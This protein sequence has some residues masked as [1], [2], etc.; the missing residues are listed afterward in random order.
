MSHHPRFGHR[1]L[2]FFGLLAALLGAALGLGVGQLAAAQKA[3]ADR[4]APRSTPAFSDDLDSFDPTLWHKADWGNPLPP[5]WNYW[6]PD[7]I[8]FADGQMHIRLDDDSCPSGCGGRPYAAGEYR[9]NAFYGYGRVEARLKTSNVPGI[10]TALFVYTGPSDGKPHDEIDIEILGEDPTKIQVGYFVND[11]GSHETTISL[12]FDASQD[13]HTYAFEWAPNRITWY[14]DGVLVHTES[15]SPLPATPGRIMMSLWAC[16]GVDDWCGR[17]NYPGAPVYAHYDWVAYT[18]MPHYGYLPLVYQRYSPP[19]TPTATPTVTPS[20]LL[21]EDFEDVRDWHAELGNGAVCGYQQD[22]GYRGRGIKVSCTTYEADDWWFVVKPID[23]NWS[24]SAEV[25]FFYKKQADSGDIYVALQDNDAE[26]WDTP[27]ARS[28]TD[29][30]EV[31]VPLAAFTRLDPA[32][33]QGNGILDLDTVRQ[34]RFRHWPGTP[35]D[36]TFW[37]DELRICPPPIT[38][39]WTPTPTAT[40]TSTWTVTPSPTSTRTL[41]PT[42]TATPTPTWTVTPSPTR[43]RTP[44]PTDTATPTPTRTVTPSPTRTRTPTP[45]DT[46]T[47]TPTKTRAP[48]PTDTATPT[49]TWTSTATR[50]PTDTPT[51]T[52]VSAFFDDLDGYDT[53]RWN[54]ADGWANGSPFA[55][56]WRADHI[57]HADSLMTLTLDD[58]PCPGGCS[59]M[60]YAC[61]EYRTDG[62]YGYGCYEARFKAAPDSGVVTSFFTYAKSPWDV[63]SGYT[64]QRN[65][66]DME[67]IGKDTTKLHLNFW[68]NSDISNSGHEYTHT[69]GFD[70]AQAFHT[71][72]FKWTLNGIEW[73]V[74]GTPVHWVAN[75]SG[76]PTPNQNDTPHRIMMN[77]W[78]V[79]ASL[80]GWAGPFVYPG[81]PVHAYY[82]WIRYTPGEGCVIATPTPTSTPTPTRTFTPTSTSTATPS[83]TWTPTYTPTATLTRTPTPTITT[84][85]GGLEDFENIGDWENVQGDLDEY[86]QSGDR[87]EGNYSFCTGGYEDPGS[88]SWVGEARLWQWGSRPTD[89]RAYSAVTLWAKRTSALTPRIALV[90]VDT[91]GGKAYLHRDGDECLNWPG[92]GWRSPITPNTWTML[93][94]PLRQGNPND[95]YY[96]TTIDW[97]RVASLSIKVYT[98]IDR[99]GPVNLCVDDMRLN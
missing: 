83:R 85:A 6:L 95:C 61:G 86:R 56:G 37:V 35:T 77:M 88:I 30:E 71:Y 73:Y 43:T 58:Q 72:G 54:K 94:F 98:D 74:D 16:T 2:A 87:V 36:V 67:L 52:P 68:A 96:P 25:R 26:V 76:D 99:Q 32:D 11:V 89:W 42:D 44:T 34:F 5:F 20:C 65:E 9:S 12:G 53:V 82:D 91:Q 31:V 57:T 75:N 78:P 24:S 41:T 19:P 59:G 7:H 69:L 64:A 3:L 51:A 55:C 80:F 60:S 14:V 4:A 13:F 62:F 18:P 29:W 27:L 63:P 45:T 23:R 1:W 93:T 70:A 47:P 10:V 81:T 49:P 48:T 79:D 21:L 46:A 97:S 8:E 28:N 33:H 40:P 84:V 90:V 92:G 15:G 38:P 39:T 66:I 50:T 17:F 22:T